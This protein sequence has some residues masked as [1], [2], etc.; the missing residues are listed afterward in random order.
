MKTN[1]AGCLICIAMS[2]SISPSFAEG[3]VSQVDKTIE[4]G[5]KAFDEG[6]YLKAERTLLR[7]H[8]LLGKASE[9][10]QKMAQVCQQ[11]GA[12]YYKEN[13][14]SEAESFYKKSQDILRGLSLDQSEIEKKLQELSTIY[15]P[16][17][18][19]SFDENA[20]AFAKQV[21][22]VC[23]SALNKDQKRHIDINL[24]QRFQ[25][26]IK[27]LIDSV[28]AGLT[29]S[30][31][32]G[33]DAAAAI[34]TPEGSPPVKQIRLDKKIAFDVLR[35]ESDGKLRLANIEGIF[36]NVGLWVKLKEFAMQLNEKN[37]P[38]AEV[39]AGAFG[40]DKIVHVDLPQN[41][42]GRLKQGIDKFDPFLGQAA[43][44][45]TLPSGATT[46]PAK[47]S[48]EAN[49]ESKIALPPEANPADSMKLE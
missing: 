12:C 38:V 13:K 33:G 5:Q 16:I 11:L 4:T 17:N 19:E 45:A 41:L 44:A 35:S 31:A 10:D 46:Q 37:S 25:Q 42:Y 24:K 15:R 49:S 34:A 48:I 36:L 23:A 14:F 22:A 6:H 47:E 29:A 9:P 28:P 43:N 20:T 40:V 39:T 7:A 26:G 1:I 3:K 32:G 30:T 27:E 8:G 2:I 18:L 21:G